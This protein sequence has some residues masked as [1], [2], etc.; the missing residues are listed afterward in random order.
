MKNA[1]QSLLSLGQAKLG[2]SLA[3]AIDNNAKSLQER[4]GLV[5]LAMM[6][7]GLSFASVG[8]AQLLSRF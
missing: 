6:L 3:L 2:K 7:I 1:N 4:R 8:I 5:A